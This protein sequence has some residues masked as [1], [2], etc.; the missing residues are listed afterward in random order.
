MFCHGV[1]TV[2]GGKLL[3][4]ERGELISQECVRVGNV[5]CSDGSKDCSL[6]R[7]VAI[8]SRQLH[9]VPVGVRSIRVL[10][11]KVKVQY[12]PVHV[13]GSGLGSGKRNVDIL[14]LQ[15]SRVETSEAGEGVVRTRA[16]CADYKSI[17]L[18]LRLAN[19]S[20]GGEGLGLCSCSVE[21]IIVPTFVGCELQVD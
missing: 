10:L 16:L 18:V 2:D 9:K 4:R 12:R 14:L 19:V 21:Q 6:V 5:V 20:Y 11:D 8:Y 1:Q 7:V 13:Q 17:V 15:E 3:Q